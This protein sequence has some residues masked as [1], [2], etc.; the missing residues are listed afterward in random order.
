MIYS[1][2]LIK[3]AAGSGVS[4]D[5][6]ILSISFLPTIWPQNGLLWHLASTLAYALTNIIH[7]L[8]DPQV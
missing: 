1:S 5:V 8:P 7:T 6:S 4:L 3:I 2:S